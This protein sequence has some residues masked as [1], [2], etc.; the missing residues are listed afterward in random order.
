MEST[1]WINT[2]FNN[3]IIKMT[4]EISIIMNNNKYVNNIE[5]KIEEMEID[6]I[7]KMNEI[8]NTYEKEDIHILYKNKNSLEILQK[9]VEIIKLISKYSLQNNQLEYIFIITCLKYLCK[10]SEIL[11]IR[12]KQPIITFNN[13]IKNTGIVRCSYKFCNYK[14][15]CTYNYG[16]KGNS[17]YQDHYVHNMVNHDVTSLISYIELNYETNTQIL[18]NK[19]ILKTINTLSFVIGHMEGELRAKCLYSEPK[20]WEKFHYINM[21][22]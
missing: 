19:E 8:K 3:D 13:N 16:K 18:H 9:E 12:L 4:N 20:D 5:V 2:F 7:T 1:N 6:Y 11:R 10:L 22:K 21:S 17:C 14:E 15:E